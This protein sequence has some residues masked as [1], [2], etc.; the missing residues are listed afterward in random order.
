MD[1]YDERFVII[2]DYFSINFKVVKTKIKR[3]QYNKRNGIR[4]R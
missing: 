2:D 3:Y 1:K 4:F